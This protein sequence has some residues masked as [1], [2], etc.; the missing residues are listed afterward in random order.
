MCRP[1]DKQLRFRR[2]DIDKI[3]SDAIGVYGLWF[4]KRCIYV[5]KAEEQ[6][7]AKRLQQHWERTHNPELAAWIQAKGPELRVAYV[8][9]EEES[10]IDALERLYIRRFQPLT[11]KIRYSSSN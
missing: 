8:I 4:G 9:T 6:P 11:N 1:Y 5:G 3:P 10:K 7:I 2:S